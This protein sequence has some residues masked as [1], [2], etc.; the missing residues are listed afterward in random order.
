M[1]AIKMALT[2]VASLAVLIGT[3][4]IGQ[5]TGAYPSGTSPF[6]DNQTPWIFRGAMLA[7]VGL[8]VLWRTSRVLR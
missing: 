8:L 1:V 6:I 5:G 4:W 3:I 7:S 2:V